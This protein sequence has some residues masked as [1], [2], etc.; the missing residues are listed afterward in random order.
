MN[1]QPDLPDADDDDDF[2]EVA[3][4]EQY[5]PVVEDEAVQMELTGPMIREMILE[6]ADYDRDP[7]GTGPFGFSHTNPIPVNG[8]IG[9][10]AYLSRLETLDGERIFFHRLGSRARVDV[11]EAVTFS[12]SQWFV[13]HLDMYHPRRSRALP[14][15]FRFTRETPWF[16]GFH[17]AVPDFPKGI[18]DLI[19]VDDPSVI[20]C[21][22]LPIPDLFLTLMTHRYERPPEHL[23][24]LDRPDHEVHGT[25]SANRFRPGR[26]TPPDDFDDD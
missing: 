24:R 18:T 1:Q 7:A 17:N 3:W 10:L 5:R 20:D 6:G 2:D 15:G 4:K 13:L 23:A 25:V 14:E 21:A 22:Y 9:Q 8:P 16:T 11:F 12:G 26:A 19:E